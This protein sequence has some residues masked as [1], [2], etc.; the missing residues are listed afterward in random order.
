MKKGAI[1]LV[2]SKEY[3]RK[4]S[5]ISLSVLCVFCLEEGGGECFA[6]LSVS[7]LINFAGPGLTS[8]TL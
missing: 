3:V 1:D 6:D 8:C 5:C 2:E 4:C 7:I